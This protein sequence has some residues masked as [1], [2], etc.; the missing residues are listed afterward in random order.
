MRQGFDMPDLMDLLPVAPAIPPTR[1]A[2]A[3]DTA[4]GRADRPAV[5]PAF[6]FVPSPAPMLGTRWLDTF[7][8]ARLYAE[9]AQ[10]SL[11]ATGE[12]GP[13]GGRGRAVA[14]AVA[15]PPG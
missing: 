9:A 2:A 6:R 10:R 3:A 14:P 12:R 11:I 7:E 13:A 1:P 4:P 5:I 8:I 15:A